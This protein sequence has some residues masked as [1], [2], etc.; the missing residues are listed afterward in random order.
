MT[1]CFQNAVNRIVFT[2]IGNYAK[3]V[4][5]RKISDDIMLLECCTYYKILPGQFITSRGLERNENGQ[6]PHF[7]GNSNTQ[8]NF[9]AAIGN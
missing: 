5:G 7:L 9:D 6:W 8:Y 2:T 1:L 3:G 4:E